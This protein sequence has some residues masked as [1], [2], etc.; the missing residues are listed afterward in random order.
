M[1]YR[2]DVIEQRRLL[3]RKATELLRAA[4]TRPRRAPR[5]RRQLPDWKRDLQIW[6]RR[7]MLT[8]GESNARS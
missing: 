1:H 2:R 8:R 5:P 7:H 3:Y 6:A 4:D